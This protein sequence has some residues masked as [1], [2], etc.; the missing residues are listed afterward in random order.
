[1]F[2]PERRT[3]A[4][5]GIIRHLRSPVGAPQYQTSCFFDKGFHLPRKKPNM[6]AAAANAAISTWMSMLPKPESR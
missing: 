2:S 5:E 3:S 4:Q 6:A 1:M